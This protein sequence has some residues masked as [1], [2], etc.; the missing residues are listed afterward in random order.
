MVRCDLMGGA[1]STVLSGRVLL[2]AAD[3]SLEL[4]GGLEA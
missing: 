4:S 3:S 2:P 1:C